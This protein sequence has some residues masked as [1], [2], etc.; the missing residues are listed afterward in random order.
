[1]RKYAVLIVLACLFSFGSAQAEEK[2]RYCHS[3]SIDYIN[4]VLAGV[5]RVVV[6]VDM[7]GLG[8]QIIYLNHLKR[9]I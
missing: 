3:S 6:A 8:V 2:K 7:V 5:E 4:P 1:M 9:P